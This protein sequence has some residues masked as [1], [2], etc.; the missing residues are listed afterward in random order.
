MFTYATWPTLWTSLT[1]IAPTFGVYNWGINPD[2]NYAA[3]VEHGGSM[4]SDKAKAALTWWLSLLDDAPPESTQ[5]TWDE[6]AATFAAGRAAQGLVYGE[7]A[8]WI[9]TNADKSK[10]VGNVGVALPPVED[11]VMADAESGEVD[12]EDLPHVRAEPAVATDGAQ[13]AHVDP[14]HA[15]MVNDGGAQ[16]GPGLRSVVV[17]GFDAEH[18]GHGGPSAHNVGGMG[19]RASGTGVPTVS[20]RR[21]EWHCLVGSADTT[22]DKRIGK[23]SAYVLPPCFPS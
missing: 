4:N 15:V 11:G 12:T 1:A 3:T 6:V 5:S 10:V 17:L 8:A 18:L 20:C 9:A 21:P 2:Q 23:I 19:A 16:V 13:S 22:R 14:I 7:N